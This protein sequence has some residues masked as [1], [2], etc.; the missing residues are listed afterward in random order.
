MAA[1]ICHGGTKVAIRYIVL[2]V[3]ASS[4]A[5]C[6]WFD[7]KVTANLTGYSTSCIEGVSYLQFPSGV[8]VQ[9]TREGRPK[10]C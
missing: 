8:T 4:L 7:R 2:V 10:T 1:A 3:L 5:G 6:G 9:Y